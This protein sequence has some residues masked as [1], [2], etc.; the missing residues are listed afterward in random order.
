MTKGHPRGAARLIRNRSPPLGWTAE[1]I[2]L[3]SLIARY[4]RGAMPSQSQ[5]RFSVL[6]ESK[7]AMV[8]LLGGILR[9]ACACDRQHDSQIRRVDVES[10]NPILR[11]RA[12]GYGADTALAEHL[13]AARY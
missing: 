11:V 1:E 3:A 7:R 12:D 5:K 13:A 9:F 8:Q 6:P 4:H 2:N 10:S